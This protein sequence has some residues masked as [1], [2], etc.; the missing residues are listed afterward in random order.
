MD[1]VRISDWACTHTMASMHHRLWNVGTSRAIRPP[2]VHHTLPFIW[3]VV[4]RC[5]FV[6]H[7]FATTQIVV[8][9]RSAVS[10]DPIEHHIEVAFHTEIDFHPARA[11]GRPLLALTIIAISLSPTHASAR[12]GC[13]I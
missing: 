8:E 11:F 2:S 6:P 1:T 7:T 10:M 9:T 4:R 3:W 12:H 5:V 13:V